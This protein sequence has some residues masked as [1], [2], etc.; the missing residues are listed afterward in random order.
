MSP[1]QTP[2]HRCSHCARE[3]VRAE[4]LV[5]H[6]RIHTKEKPFSCKL[7]EKSFSRTDLLRRHEKKSHPSRL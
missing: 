7:C 4:H 6:E 1:L 5:R 2:S 3:F